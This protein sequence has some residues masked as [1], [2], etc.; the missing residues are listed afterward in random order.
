VIIGIDPGVTGAIAFLGERVIDMPIMSA[1]KKGKRNQIN[2]AELYNILKEVPGDSIVYLEKT[3]AMPKN[4]AI[5]SYSQGDSNG[6]IRAVCACLGLRV[7]RVTP[8]AWKKHYS[9][10]SDKETVRAKAIELFPDAPLSRKKDHNRA[11]ALLI[12]EY[13]KNISKN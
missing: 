8:Q 6:C 13:G 7:E 4:G 3:H 12:A 2:A 10:G 9:L 5:A 1:D 11:E